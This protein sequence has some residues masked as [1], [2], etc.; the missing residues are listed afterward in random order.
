MN[1]LCKQVASPGRCFEFESFQAQPKTVK[2]LTLT[3]QLMPSI[4]KN[5]QIPSELSLRYFFEWSYDCISCKR[6]PL[7]KHLGWLRL[8]LRPGGFFLDPSR[9]MG[10]THQPLGVLSVPG[11]C[12]SWSTQAWICLLRGCLKY[13]KKIATHIS[14]WI[15]ELRGWNQE[16]GGFGLLVF[17]GPNSSP[18]SCRQLSRAL[19]FAKSQGT[20][21]ITA[22]CSAAPLNVWE[23][24]SLIV[25]QGF[26]G[27]LEVFILRPH[28]EVGNT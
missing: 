2:L 22:T 25:P 3:M 11:L 28:V 7:V 24:Y 13:A 19:V 6:E 18:N 26:A 4:P 5:P 21:Q 20:G 9:P 16:V 8:L 15:G 10:F 17:S 23:L 12:V 14:I 27:F 1:F